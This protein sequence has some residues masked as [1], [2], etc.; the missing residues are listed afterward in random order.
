MLRRSAFAL[1]LATRIAAGASLGLPMLPSTAWAHVICGNRTFPVTLTMDD[2]GVADEASLPTIQYTPI[3]QS[4]GGGQVMS[5]GFEW[6]KLITEKF[7]LAINGGY[8]ASDSGGVNEKGWNNLS[9]TAKD[10]LLCS[11]AN[12]FVASVGVVRAF[13]RTGSS[14]LVNNGLIDSTSSTSPVLYFGK[15]FGDL[16]IGYLRPFAITGEL[17]YAFTDTESAKPNSW[18]YALSLQYSPSYL[19]QSVKDIGLP[20]FISRLTPL[21]EVALTTPRGQRTT[22][23][24][25]PGLLYNASWFQVGAEAIIPANAATRRTQGTGFIAQFHLYF[26]DLFPTTV[27]RPIFGG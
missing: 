15:G 24:I 5:Y 9:L 8:L 18:N 26:D 4:A 14:Q 20:D 7:M 6:D 16:P 25:A 19:Q 22:G 3:P 11:E 21:V 17:A 10:E 1:A 27:G 13:A 23:T 2:P 12:E